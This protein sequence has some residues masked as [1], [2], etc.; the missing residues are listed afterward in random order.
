[1]TP[2]LPG[3][4]IEQ[5]MPKMHTINWRMEFIPTCPVLWII[6][7]PPPSLSWWW[8]VNNATSATQSS[9]WS[10]YI[11][12]KKLVHHVGHLYARIIFFPLF[13]HKVSLKSARYDCATVVTFDFSMVTCLFCTKPNVFH[14]KATKF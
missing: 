4:S 10:I 11:Q 8:F 1:M 3:T 14:I 9:V 12:S 13:L 6:P 5:I 2:N 7:S